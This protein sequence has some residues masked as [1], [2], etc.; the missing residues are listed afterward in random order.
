M[1]TAIALRHYPSYNVETLPAIPL[2]NASH[3]SSDVAHMKASGRSRA[4]RCRFIFPGGIESNFLQCLHRATQSP[5]GVQK[6]IPMRE[7]ALVIVRAGDR[8][9]DQVNETKR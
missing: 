3:K 6:D 8:T 7:R 4:A 5:Y 1:E 2:F 9:I